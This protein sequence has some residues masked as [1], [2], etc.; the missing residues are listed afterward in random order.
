MRIG[1]I[2]SVWISVPPHGFGF[3]AQEYLAYHLAEGLMRKGHDVTIFASGGSKTS[4]RLVSISDKPVINIDFPDPKIKDM[5]ELM[6]VSACYKMAD[7]FDI[8]HNQLLPYGLLFAD[9][10]R[11]PTIHTL[12][13]Q[14]YANR[15]NIFLYQRYKDQNFVSI[16]DA[17]R[18]IFPN[19]SYK[20]T[21][22]NGTDTNFYSYKENPTGDYLLYLG[23]M[24]RYKGIHS[25]IQIAQ[26]LNMKLKIASP[27]PFKTQV[28]YK[29]VMDYYSQQIK[30][31][32]SGSIEHIEEIVGEEKVHLI[33]N[34]KL[35]IFPVEREE[36]FG[37][38]VIEA[39]SCG[40]PVVSYAIGALPELIVDNKTGYL[41][42][43]NKI[44]TKKNYTIKKSGT[45][46]L[47]EAVKHV[48]MLNDFD[49][50]ALRKNARNH[51][52]KTFTVQTMVDQYDSLY[53]KMI[54]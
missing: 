33:Q 32:L 30:P 13:H 18:T 51:V 5:F 53:K 42:D 54:Q 46:G 12:H 41:I 4:A 3:G 26:K 52:E 6:N 44:T 31:F 11:V 28:D 47:Q 49:Y 34:A 20:T 2:A 9:I 21:I 10:T 43:L 24:K 14:I 37:M 36:P 35:L 38:T 7:S 17:Q 27:L 22:Y 19:L 29:E 50:K 45:E 39:M 25:A 16:S 15:A 40:T 8:I 23:R 1:I 48:I